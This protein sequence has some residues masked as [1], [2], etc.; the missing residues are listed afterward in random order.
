M[1]TDVPHDTS[2]ETVSSLTDLAALVKRCSTLHI[3]VSAGPA[4]DHASP[5]IDPESGLEMPGI[6]AAPLLAPEWWR[7]PLEDWLARQLVHV[8]GSGGPGVRPWLL[9]GTDMG[10]GPDGEPLL[11]HVRPV[12]WLADEVLEEAASRYA[13]RFGTSVGAG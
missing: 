4:A 5:A 3:R 9:T 7:R 13:T 12:G 10:T 11:G 1:R 6:A 8:E 2:M